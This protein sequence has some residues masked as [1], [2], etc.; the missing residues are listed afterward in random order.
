V[1]SR[2]QLLA[3][4]LT[5]RMIEVRVR[6][7]RLHPVYRGVYAVG[8]PDLTDR[9]RW[10]AGV[11]AAGADAVLSHRS[12][13]ALWGL[14]PWPGRQVEVTCPSGSR[15]RGLTAHRSRVPAGDRTVMDHI[16]V[17]TVTRT[18][19]DLR[20]VLP[21]VEVERAVH[22]A[23]RTGRVDRAPA[24][25]PEGSQ[26]SRSPLEVAFL[27]LCRD[28]GLPRPEVN[29][30]VQGRLRDFFWPEHRLVV[31]TDGRASHLTPTA[32]EDDRERDVLLMEAGYRVRRFT[33]RQITER[34]AWVAAR[35]RAALAET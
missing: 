4:G 9:G 1:V 7:G 17:T 2:A 11:L 15:K 21:P 14:R 35:V 13:A 16:P 6:N 30:M 28:H 32:F 26:R 31:E 12:A 10:M 24:G 22:Q 20:R 18:L 5:A 27:R 25:H 29:V 3:A 8:R 34:P 19:A 33:Y 23:Y